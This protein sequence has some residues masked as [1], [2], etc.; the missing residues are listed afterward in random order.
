MNFDQRKDDQPICSGELPVVTGSP[1]DLSH[2]P[3][4]DE[5]E[6]TPFS[7]W[8]LPVSLFVATIFTTLWAGAYLPYTL[9]KR[10]PVDFLL[11]SPGS[12]WSGIPFAA[13]LLFILVT[14]ECG[15]YVLS[16]I[17]GVPASLPLFIPGL[18]YFI[19]TFGA[20]IRLKGPIVNRCALFDI[21][22][23]G[24]LAGFIAAVV[25]LIIGLNLSTVI[26]RTGTH[27]WQLG[28]P[29]LSQFIAWLVVGPLPP[30]ATIEIH[31]IGV[32][33]WFGLLVTSLNLIPIGQLDGGHVA[34]ALWGKHQRTMAFIMVPILIVLGYVGWQ[35]WWVWAFMAGLWGLGHPPVHDTHVPLGRKRVIVGWIAVAVFVVTFAPV[36]FSFH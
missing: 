30:Q 4:D 25:A 7:K 3:P 10:G 2:L 24:P 20:I 18:P 8:I 26:D 29:L 6:E 5:F 35:G 19:G 12:L 28:A 14:H 31:P 22:V 21:G 13:T 36:P 33:A 9:G 15:H 34:Y 11:D 27:G 1:E 17:H 16:R 23:S 32:A